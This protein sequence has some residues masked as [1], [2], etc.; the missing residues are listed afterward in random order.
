MAQDFFVDDSRALDR[1]LGGL[2]S[3][4]TTLYLREACN[5]ATKP[6]EQHDDTP[7]LQTLNNLLG[8]KVEGGQLPSAYASLH[9]IKPHA[10]EN[11][12]ES[13]GAVKAFMQEA[14]AGAY[15][16]SPSGHERREIERRAAALVAEQDQLLLQVTNKLLE[17]RKE[18]IESLAKSNEFPPNVKT[19]LE[20]ATE[21]ASQSIAHTQ[22]VLSIVAG[23][24]RT[25]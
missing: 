1:Y 22:K 21:A 25:A 16:D 17:K 6:T 10:G 8:F 2:Y 18:G 5:I 4:L 7:A 24:Q 15:G 11:P 13:Y 20:S 12:F 9:K 23:A 19:L 14:I 3:E